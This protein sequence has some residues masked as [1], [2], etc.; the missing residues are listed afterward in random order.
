M[1]NV[2]SVQNGSSAVIWPSEG[3]TRVPYEV[4]SDRSIYERE[5]DMNG[6]KPRSFEDERGVFSASRQRFPIRE[7]TKPRAS[8]TR[9]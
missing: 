7:I 2:V 3:L 1:S 4:Y 8:G 6:N 5:Q 9:P